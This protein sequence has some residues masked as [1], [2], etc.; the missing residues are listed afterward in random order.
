ME[1][2]NEKYLAYFKIEGNSIND[3]YFDAR[4][5]ADALIGIDEIFK[6]YLYKK[7]PELSQLEFELPV[8]TR[9]GSWETLIPENIGDWINFILLTGGGYYTTSFLK[10]MAKNDVG[11]KGFKDVFKSIIKSIKW[12]I[13][14]ANHLKSMNYKRF[15]NVKFENKGGIQFIGIENNEGEILYVPKQFLDEFSEIP[16]TIFSRLAKLVEF[17]RELFIDFNPNEERD[18]DDLPYSANI[19]SNNKFVFYKSEEIED[20]LFPELTHSSYVELEG[21]ITRGNENSNTIGFEYNGHILTCYP[22][23]GNI[24]E[25]SDYFFKDCI[26]MGYVNRMDKNGIYMEK[27]PKIIFSGFTLINPRK[28]EDELPF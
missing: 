23:N 2:N 16:G 27:R 17:D 11:D 25:Y 22:S 18:K 12:S 15:E 8:R 24:V 10:N 19:T 9:K 20:S 28:D 7:S 26:I 13:A 3:G 5:S 14:L 21:H 4:K 1:D 6:Y